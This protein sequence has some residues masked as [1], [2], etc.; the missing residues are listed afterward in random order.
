MSEEY[1][2]IVDENGNLTGEKELRSVCHA[3]GLWHRTVHIHLFREKDKQIEL[4]THQQS[5]KKAGSFG[6]WD[7]RFGGHLKSGTPLN[8]T[9]LNEMQDEIGLDIK[10]SDLI[11]GFKDKRDRNMNRELVHA[12]YLPFSKKFSELLF[13]DGEVEQVKWRNFKEIENAINENQTYWG[14]RLDDLYTTK[15]DLLSK[16]T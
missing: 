11:V 14:T 6:K 16:I 10:I 5:P 3:K 9:I 8:E 2:D 12:Y 13:F 4:L 1:L 7:I 15:K